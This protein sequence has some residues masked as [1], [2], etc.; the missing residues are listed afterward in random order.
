MALMLSGCGNILNEP[1]MGGD[2]ESELSTSIPTPEQVDTKQE[3]YKDK[4]GKYEHIKKFKEGNKTQEVTEYVDPKGNKGYQVTETEDRK[5][6]LY[7][8]SYGKG[9]EK[10]SRSYDWTLISNSTTTDEEI[11]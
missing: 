3:D 4:E 7:M 2:V 8:R 11:N 10:D 1:P 5:D 9:I 6:G